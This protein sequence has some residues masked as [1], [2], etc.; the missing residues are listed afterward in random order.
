[1][2]VASV[3]LPE[4]DGVNG[5]NTEKRRNEDDPKKRARDVSR[6]AYLLAPRIAR[7]VEVR[8]RFGE[9]AVNERAALSPNLPLASTH[10]ATR[11]ASIR[12]GP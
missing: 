12:V 7:W 11:G 5:F 6:T 3:E 8:G 10:R 9:N 4:G 1:M 2:G